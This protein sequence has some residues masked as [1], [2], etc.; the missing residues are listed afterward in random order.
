M[1][2]FDVP[3]FSSKIASCWVG[4]APSL[5]VFMGVPWDRIIERGICK[6]A[7]KRRRQVRCIDVKSWALTSHKY[8]RLEAL[9]PGF[10]VPGRQGRRKE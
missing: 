9:R 4:K 5:G 3:F 6:G 1:M 10:T 8:E 7:R 2:F